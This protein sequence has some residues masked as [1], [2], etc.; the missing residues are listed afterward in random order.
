MGVRRAVGAGPFVVFR[1]KTLGG[2][3]SAFHPGPH[4]ATTFRGYYDQPQDFAPPLPGAPPTGVVL[5]VV[6]QVFFGGGCWFLRALN[7]AVGAGWVLIVR[8]NCDQR[9][10]YPFHCIMS[11]LQVCS[12]RKRHNGT[13]PKNFHNDKSCGPGTLRTQ[14]C[15]AAYV[16]IRSSIL[17]FRAYEIKHLF[18]PN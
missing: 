17:T 14:L 10:V 12:S 18:C 3:G 16:F 6:A 4:R 15:L 11:P 1:V 8:Y 2:N 5:T 7:R 13:L 9:T